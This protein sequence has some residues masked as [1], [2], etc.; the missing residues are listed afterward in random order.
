MRNRGVFVLKF[1]FLAEN[2]MVVFL[3]DSFQKDAELWSFFSFRI[4]HSKAP[5]ATAA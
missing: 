1:W 5:D 2:Q 4:H 3:P